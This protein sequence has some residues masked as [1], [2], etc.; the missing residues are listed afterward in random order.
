MRRFSV[1][2][3]WR[4]RPELQETLG[5][6][7][8][9]VERHAQEVLVVNCGGDV[10]QAQAAIEAQSLSNVRHIL[11]PAPDFNGPLARNIGALL[12][13]AELLFF[14]DADIV[15]ESD[16]FAQ[17]E[18]LLDLGRRVVTI[19]TVR[20]SRPRDRSLPACVSEIITT[21][22]IVFRDG[23]RVRLV[24]FAGTDGSRCGPGLLL[25]KRTDFV[26]AGG[27]NSELAGWGYDDVDLLIRLQ[28]SAGHR[29]VAAG[30]VLHRSHGDDV[31]AIRHGSAVQNSQ[32]N[33]LHCFANYARG[34]Y[35]GSY[36]RDA[37]LW[38]HKVRAIPGAVQSDPAASSGTDVGPRHADPG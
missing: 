17:A 23:R 15:L 37:A 34:D 18:P 9:L 27:F 30:T 19:R 20:E 33:R 11:V 25:I 28:L 22:K 29:V 14:L 12:S 7:A 31:R 36:E 10:R 5:L 32:R 13:A 3:P 16:I 26:D 35:R 24:N 8:P 6:N 38:H 21:Q 1:V 2:V 4:N